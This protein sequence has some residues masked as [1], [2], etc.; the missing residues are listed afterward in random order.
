VFERTADLESRFGDNE[1][2]L[3]VWHPSEYPSVAGVDDNVVF[4]G[5]CQAL[6]SACTV[7]ED[8]GV[9]IAVEITR[10]GSIG[11]AESFLRVISTAI[12]TPLSSATVQADDKA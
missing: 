10:A 2:P 3:L 7:A 6:S 4:Q 1:C 5:L 12:C 8:K 11:S 9:H